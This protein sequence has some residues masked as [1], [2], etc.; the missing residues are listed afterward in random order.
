VR[1]SL[2]VF[3]TT[4]V[5]WLCDIELGIP[6]SSLS[7][8]VLRILVADFLSAYIFKKNSIKTV[9]LYIFLYDKFYFYVLYI[10]NILFGKEIC[11][12]FHYKTLIP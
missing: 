1:V 4:R 5:A 7:V 6:R 8:V 12:H 2:V 9:Q 3:L 10:K 11:F